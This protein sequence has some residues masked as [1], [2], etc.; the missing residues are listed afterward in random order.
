MMMA[1]INLG[2]VAGT[3]GAGKTGPLRTR[4]ERRKLRSRH[5]RISPQRIK[6]T[7]FTGLRGRRYCLYVRALGPEPVGVLG[8]T[9]E[10]SARL[11]KFP[12]TVCSRRSRAS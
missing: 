10:M 8:R 5:E 1:T 11:E 3:G 7:E 2:L 9:V 6:A 4:A 12:S